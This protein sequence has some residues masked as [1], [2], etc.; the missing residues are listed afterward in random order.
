[1]DLALEPDLTLGRRQIAADALEQR[2]LPAAGWP[3]QHE[4]I[5]LQHLETD[6]IGGGDQMV[7]RLVLD[8][9]A[10]HVEQRLGCLGGRIHSCRFRG[11]RY[12][13]RHPSA[14][15]TLD[16]LVISSASGRAVRQ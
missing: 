5:A 1:D 3:E 7:L 15:P 9:D 2:R 16:I 4:S 12:A 6:A 8:G 11:E 10:T 13:R 14:P